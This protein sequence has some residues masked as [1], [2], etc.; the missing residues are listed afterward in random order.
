MLP[1]PSFSISEDFDKLSKEEQEWQIELFR[2]RLVH[3]YHNLTT[4][5]YNKI[6]HKVVFSEDEAALA[7]TDVGEC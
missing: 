4:A 2:H 6:Q 3:Y 7:D 1:Y 5:V